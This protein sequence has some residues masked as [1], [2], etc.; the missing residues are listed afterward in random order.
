MRGL[1]VASLGV[2][3]LVAVMLA[4][5]LA[6]PWKLM[7]LD[8]ERP[9]QYAMDVYLHGR[10]VIQTD[11]TGDVA[12]KPPVYPW[13]VAIASHLTGGVTRLSVYLPTAIGIAGTALVV[14][15]L[16]WRVL[17]PWAGLF[18]ALSFCCSTWAFKMV[19]LAR[20]DPMFCLF[21]SLSSASALLAWHARREGRSAVG[22][23]LAFWGFATLAG[24]TKSPLG[25][26]IGAMGLLAAVWEYRK[27]GRRTGTHRRAWMLANLGGLVL[28]VGVLAGWLFWA[29]AIEGDRVLDKLLG[30]ELIGHAVR[31]A[32]GDPPLVGFWKPWV[33][34]L[35]RYLPWSLVAIVGAVLIV[36]TPAVDARAR[37]LER[38][39]VC[40]LVGGLVLFSIFPHQRPDLLLPLIPPAALIV[41][42][43]LALWTHSSMLSRQR[44]G[45]PIVVQ[46]VTMWLQRLGSRRVRVLLAG[47]IVGIGLSAEATIYLFIEPRG[48][49]SEP[50][51]GPTRMDKI[52]RT[53]EMRDLARTIEAMGVDR[54]RLIFAGGAKALQIFLGVK[55][56]IVGIEDARRR[57]ASAEQVWVLSE[58][59][60]EGTRVLLAHEGVRGERVYL[61]TN[62]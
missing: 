52:V 32:A 4:I 44:R 6:G 46:S 41:G 16:G 2:V 33:Y 23:T 15:H 17:G 18:G 58:E 3:A 45:W 49:T 7:D 37:R 26:V 27:V 55:E 9:V 34:F 31:S 5:R 40:W 61:S 10:W 12:S 1:L 13:L 19:H 39:C 28:F 62:R 25:L 11:S 38:F 56:P 30:R 47:L 54:D 8:Q 42:R 53:R 36:R 50:P 24:M 22:A 48:A 57:L 60:I 51:A 35:T 29:R 20:T 14:L 21:V 43:T 59:P